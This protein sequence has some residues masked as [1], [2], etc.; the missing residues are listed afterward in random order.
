MSSESERWQKIGDIFDRVADLPPSQRNGLLDQ[1]CAED[2]AL[3]E[4]IESLL[5]ADAAAA[6]FDHGFDSAR[7]AA[8]RAWDEEAGETV[9]H[10]IGAWRVVRE[11]GRGGMGVV[12]LVDRADGQYEQRAALKLIK[13]GMDSEAILARF[14]RERQILARLDHP[15]IA[16]LLDGGIAD[17]GRPFFVME[18][19][20]GLPLIDYCNAHAADVAS[21]IE[22]FVQVCA[23]VQ[24]AHGRL[25]VHRDIKPTNILVTA[26]GEAKLLDFGIAKLTNA[27]SADTVT[28]LWRDSPLTPAYAAPE[29]L[30][31]E[32]ASVAS[33]VYAL[34]GVLYELLAGKRPFGSNDAPT[35][36]EMRRLVETTPPPAPSAVV[37]RDA[38]VPGK[39][40]RGDLD[41]IVLKAMQRDPARRYATV[42]ALAA[43]LHRYRQGLPISARRDSATYRVGKFIGRHRLGVAASVAFVVVLMAGVVLALWQE[44][45]K[46][47]E[48]Q[49]AQEVT[50]FL[51][52]LFAG[53]DPELTRGSRLS[54]QDLL[55]QGSEKLNAQADIGPLVRARLL[56]TIAHT[57]AALGLYDRALPLARQALALRRAQ[58]GNAS[59]DSAESADELGTIHLSKGEYDK[60]EPLLREALQTQRDALAADAPAVIA[61]LG[62]VAALMQDRG[63]FAGAD[64]LYRQALDASGRRFGEDSAEHARRLDDY[65]TNLDNL[66]RRTDAEAAYR[67]ALAIREKRFG[68]DSAEAAVSLQNLGVHLDQDG[69]YA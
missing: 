51:V 66:G 39:V 34:G 54:A 12:L 40:L 64:R 14:L 48:A 17:D 38:P 28:A 33:D 6:G 35:L 43:D 41:T 31:G 26:Q 5:R 63:D 59:L 58:G 69:D 52:G 61:S 21:R 24:F 27:R 47:R 57:Y 15:H 13:R 65:A 9:G 67:R 16:R 11:L 53:A 68:P 25:V 3:R 49:A 8:V 29:Q 50:N 46:A 36:E 56:H 10:G 19:V 60:A 30:R 20:E 2:P 37:V 32:A 45:Q 18:Y 44:R 7:V 55:D 22:L 4:S 62:N 1:L 42:E 23:A